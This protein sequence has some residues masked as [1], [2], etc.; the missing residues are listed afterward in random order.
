MSTQTRTSAADRFFDSLVERQASVFDA[1]RSAAE[2]NHR[3]TR[4]VIEGARQTNLDWTEVGRRFLKNPTDLIGLYEAISEAVGNQQ[5]RVL[6]LSREWIEDVVES[7]RESREVFRQGIGDWREAIERVQESAPTF[8]R[9]S[10]WS[11]RNNDKQPAE[12]AEKS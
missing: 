9:R 5:S 6:A 12:A 11:R 8:L 1:V 2:R 10:G 4:S 7:Q 3:F